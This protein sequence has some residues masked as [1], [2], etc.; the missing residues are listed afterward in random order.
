MATEGTSKIF[1]HGTA[2]T[3]FASIPAKVATDSAFPFS[4]EEK[5]VVEIIGDVLVFRKR[6]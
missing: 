2:N 1:K 3:R 6:D 4:D 5:V